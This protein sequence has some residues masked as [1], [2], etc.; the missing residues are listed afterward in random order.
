MNRTVTSPLAVAVD[1]LRSTSACHTFTT[2]SA[3]SRDALGDRSLP[4]SSFSMRSERRVGRE[5]SSSGTVSG[6]SFRGS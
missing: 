1:D 5:R 3:S 2:L 6:V 4:V